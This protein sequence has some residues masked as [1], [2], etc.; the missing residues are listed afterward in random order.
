VETFASTRRTVELHML[1]DDH[2]LLSSLPYIWEHSARFLG[3][4]S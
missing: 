3:L 4:E 2:Q 1:E